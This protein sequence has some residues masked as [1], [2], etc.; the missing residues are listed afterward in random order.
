LLVIPPFIVLVL[1]SISPT[2]MVRSLS[3]ILLVHIPI[4][5]P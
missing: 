4:F 3:S 5:C 1:W 2:L